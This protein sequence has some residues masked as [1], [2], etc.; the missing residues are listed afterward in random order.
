MAKVTV[1]ELMDGM[2]VNEKTYE[3]YLEDNGTLDTVLSVNGFPVAFSQ[4]YASEFRSIGGDKSQRGVM[5]TPEGFK[6]LAYEAIEAY[7]EHLSI[8]ETVKA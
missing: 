4:E 7:E 6:T 2:P 3:V 5:L 1:N 8:Y